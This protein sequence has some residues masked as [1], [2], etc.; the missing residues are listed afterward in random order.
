MKLPL[1]IHQAR[2]GA[3]EFKVIRP[4]RPPERAVLSEGRW[5]LDAEVDQ[6][7]A[8]LIAG[9]WALAATSP[10][11]LVHVPLRRDDPATG[12][13]GLDLVLLHHSLQFAPS[14]WKELRAKLGAGRARTA[15][16]PGPTAFD[17]A[18]DHYPQERHH[19]E[20]RDRFHTRVH[21][22]TLFLTGSATLFADTA[23][24]FADVAHNGS[25]HV[26]AHPAR[27]H[28]C[29]ELDQGNGYFGSGS[30]LH[31]VYRDE[32]PDY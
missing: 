29:V 11:S 5:Y 12:R 26:Y 22:E 17:P 21:T 7:A 2:L 28:Y 18:V 4:A 8:Q 3:A 16:L 24:V 14:R 23:W 20:N 10:R 32:W 19:K 25:G 31:V 9:L 15:D 13:P 6:G 30:G 1:T 27:R